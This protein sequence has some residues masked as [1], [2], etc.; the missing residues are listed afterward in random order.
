MGRTER[1]QIL[2]IQP[3]N[4]WFGKF[5]TLLKFVL[6]CFQPTVSKKKGGAKSSSEDE[7][8]PSTTRKVMADFHSSVR[9]AKHS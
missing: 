9:G 2:S 5:D 7:N 6:F 1:V 8:T 3:K 4:S